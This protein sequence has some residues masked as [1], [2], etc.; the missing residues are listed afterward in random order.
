MRHILLFPFTEENKNLL[1]SKGYLSLAT[2]Q[3]ANS[4]TFIAISRE[5]IDKALEDMIGLY[6]YMLD[7]NLNESIESISKN[8]LPAI[9]T[10]SGWHGNRTL[11]LVPLDSLMS[12]M[13]SS[14]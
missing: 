11:T 10:L 6:R 1:K 14:N 7:A 13:G 5:G 2:K 3:R 12:F 9:V 8:N 4:Y